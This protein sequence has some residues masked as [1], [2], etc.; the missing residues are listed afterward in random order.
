LIGGL[1]A[2]QKFEY[3]CRQTWMHENR[4]A[5]NGLLAGSHN[6]ANRI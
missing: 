6:A 4:I 3:G 1:C 5:F 2:P